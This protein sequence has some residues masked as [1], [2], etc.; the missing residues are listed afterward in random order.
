MFRPSLENLL[1]TGPY[2]L[3]LQALIPATQR[4]TSF[5]LAQC[6]PLES[7]ANVNVT[8]CDSGEDHDE[9]FPSIL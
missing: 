2:A 4:A 8:S 6:T 9:P 3:F 1:S 7:D 5:R